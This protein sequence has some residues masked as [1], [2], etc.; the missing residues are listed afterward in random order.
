MPYI[1]IKLLE[2]RTAEQKRKAAEEIIEAT[3]K[4]L[5]A[6][7][8]AIHVTF[9]EISKENILKGEWLED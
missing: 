9:E 6:P 5:N 4:N 2:G 8:S 1:T 3:S 7:K